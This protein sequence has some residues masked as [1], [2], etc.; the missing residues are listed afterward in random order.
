MMKPYLR[1]RQREA[2]VST[3]TGIV[4]TVAVHVLA[5]LLCVFTGM[6]YIYPPPQ[7]Q[8]FLVD[9]S[10]DEPQP[11]R[12]QNRGRQP[13]AE[14]ID[15]TKPVAAVLCSISVMSR[16]LCRRRKSTKTPCSRE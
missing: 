3:V 7:E 2:K 8:T 9:F 16:L 11:V 4:L 12:R 10:E 13:Q 5:C 6:K 14:E 15:K 1:D